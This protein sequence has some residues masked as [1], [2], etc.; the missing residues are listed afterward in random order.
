MAQHTSRILLHLADG[1]RYPIDPDDIY[2]L[3]AEGGE[4][5]IRTRAAETLLD[6]RPLGDLEPLFLPFGFVR[7]HRSFVVNPHRIRLIRPRRN[8]GWEVKLAPP[9]NRVLP[10]SRDLTEYL[11]AVF[12]E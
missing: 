11:W 5:H 4:T 6:V 10:V 2:L 7:I 9:V 12:G 3:E 8:E 1:T